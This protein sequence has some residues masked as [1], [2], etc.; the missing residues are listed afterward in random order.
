MSKFVSQNL[1]KYI[2]TNPAINS[3]QNSEQIYLSLKQ[4]NFKI[5]K[6][7][8][9]LT[10]KD[11][12]NNNI[13]IKLSGTTC[14]LIIILNSHLICANVGDSRSI[15]IYNEDNDPELI[16]CKI[17]PLS[18]DQKLEIPE[19]KNRIIISGGIV[20]QV[21][22]SRGIA[23][24]P[25]RV[26]KPGKNYPGLAMSRSIGDSIAKNL[27]VIAEP[28]V[29]EYNLDF[30]TKFVVM[31]SDGIWEFLSN[32]DVKKIGKPFYLNY[33]SRELCEELYNS[34]LIQ[35]KINDEVVDDITA[36]VIYF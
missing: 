32:E 23:S 24:G 21:K 4:D 11:I 9:I 8:Y 17:F 30:K 2:T 35:W 10:D 6:Q 18:K 12:H 22:D 25:L 36:I 29:M 20:E 28:D 26:F 31:G 7:A 13:D 14:N 34:A 15:L 1:I 33:D 3:L 16:N 5:I 27:G 19:E